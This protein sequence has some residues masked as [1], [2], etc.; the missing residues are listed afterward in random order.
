[1]KELYGGCDAW[2]FATRNEGFG[3][4]I[5]EAMACRT[6]GDRHAGRGG[7]GTDGAGGGIMVPPEDPGEMADAI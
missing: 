4:P 3:L 2:L 1:M 6:P 7:A 5:L